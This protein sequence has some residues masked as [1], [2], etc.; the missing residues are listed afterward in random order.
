MVKISNTWVAKVFE[1]LTN[2]SNWKKGQMHR[3][4]VLTPCILFISF[5]LSRFLRIILKFKANNKIDSII[6]D[7]LFSN[8]IC[9]T[10]YAH[11]SRNEK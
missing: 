5:S 11:K 10:R 9:E 3:T 6:N 2:V 4:S 1:K 8:H 7:F